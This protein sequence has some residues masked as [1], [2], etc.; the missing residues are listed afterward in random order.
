MSP[1]GF[2][3]KVDNSSQN[4]ADNHPHKLVPVKEWDT[5]Q[6]RFGPVVK[7]GPQNKHVLDY[8][9]QVPPAPCTRFVRRIHCGL[10]I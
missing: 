8:K 3:R 1:F 7:W 4:R 6:G 5:D 2:G 9:E 10:R